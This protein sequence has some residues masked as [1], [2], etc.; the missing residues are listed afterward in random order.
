MESLPEPQKSKSWAG[1]GAAL[2]GIV[3]IVIIAFFALPNLLSLTS[4]ITAENTTSTFHVTNGSTTNGSSVEITYPSNYDVLANYA[5][6]MINQN[7]TASGLDSVTLSPIPSGQQHADSM[8]RNDYFSHWDAQ[9]YKPYM[10]YTLLNGTGFVEENVAYEYTSLP[11]FVTLQSV[12]KAI[13]DLEWQMMYNDSACCNNGH[14]NNILN[15]YHNRVS[16]GIAYDSTHVYFV[17]DFETYYINMNSPIET[18]NGNVVLEGNTSQ[19]LN[20]TS[21][22]IFYDSTP[23]PISPQTLNSVY[24]GSYTPGTFVGGVVPPCNSLFGGCSQ[25][26]TGLT[27]KAT[28]WTV[29]SNAVDIQFSLS[30]FVQR[31]GNGVYTI[32]M[33]QGDQNNP[34]YLT[35]ISI[36]VSS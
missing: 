6:S 31:S 13:N 16:I 20:P 21:V 7:R 29:T 30:A 5:L 32:T 25:F 18:S 33:M 35:S 22:L 10:R 2:F 36:F 4:I 11:S 1:V 3:L 19:T 24:D 12:E 17:E 14:R 8:L 26:S 15:P 9:G 23:Q 34:E 27:V 28:T